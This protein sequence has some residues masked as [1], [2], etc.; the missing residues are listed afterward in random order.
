M[1]VDG[2]EEARRGKLM[3]LAEAAAPEGSEARVV[4]STVPAHVSLCV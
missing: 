1:P 2:M 4:H 3:S